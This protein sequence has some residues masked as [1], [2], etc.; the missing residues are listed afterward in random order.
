MPPRFARRVIAWPLLGG[1]IATVAFP[2][3]PR[4]IEKPS[5]GELATSAVVVFQSSLLGDGM[6]QRPK[7]SDL[8]IRSDLPGWVV[9][10][11]R[12]NGVK[13]ISRL[14]EMTDRELLMLPG[15]GPRIIEI[16][17]SRVTVAQVPPDQHM[18]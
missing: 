1:S 11:L 3:T 16:I 14:R 15:V 10:V 5:V 9:K 12:A 7:R 18:H 2:T 17:R 4:S 13:R 6:S 8:I